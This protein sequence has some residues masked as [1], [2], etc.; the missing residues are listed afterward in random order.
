MGFDLLVQCL[1]I[2][3]C[4]YQVGQDLCTLHFTYLENMIA[5]KIRTKSI[6]LKHHRSFWRPLGISIAALYYWELNNGGEAI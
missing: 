6:L 4:T 3:H 5:I 1:R 2:V